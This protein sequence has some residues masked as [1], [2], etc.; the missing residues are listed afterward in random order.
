MIIPGDFVR[1]GVIE[2]VIIRTY[3]YLILA[4][5]AAANHASRG[6]TRRAY[7]Y[8]HK[9]FG[10]PGLIGDAH[11]HLQPRNQPLPLYSLKV[12]LV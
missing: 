6:R 3:A 12:S 9:S 7:Y 2:R 11:R 8:P 10:I 4:F 5:V 1:F